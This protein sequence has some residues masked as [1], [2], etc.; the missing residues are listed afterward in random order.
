[1]SKKDI[2]LNVTKHAKERI[3]ERCGLPKKAVERSV[4]N[5]WSNGLTHREC[6][7][8]LRKYVDSLYF[9]NKTAGEIR[10]FNNHTFMFTKSGTLITVLPLP[11]YL[12]NL[13]AKI[14]KSKNN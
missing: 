1:M 6:K 7:G 5:A 2:E 10:V 12:Q 13:A 4:V 3:R 11:A 14:K 8:N 9:N